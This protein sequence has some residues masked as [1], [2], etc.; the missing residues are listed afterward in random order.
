MECETHDSGT[1]PHW[2]TLALELPFL[3]GTPLGQRADVGGTIAHM[4]AAGVETSSGRGKW[5]GPVV[6][7]VLDRMD[8]INEVVA[9]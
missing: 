2:H 3:G 5:Q 6:K 8:R 1:L 9:N 4:N 7:R